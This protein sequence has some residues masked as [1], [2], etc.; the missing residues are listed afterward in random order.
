[1]AMAQRILDKYFIDGGRAPNRPYRPH[2]TL[3]ISPS[4]AAIELSL[5][6]NFSEV[7][8]AKEGHSGT[9]GINMLEKIQ[10]ANLSAILGAMLADVDYVVMGAGVPREIPRLL[11]E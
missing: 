4:R 11:T 6:G 2:P 8:L 7:W 3:T 5:L 10:T 9:V 1:P